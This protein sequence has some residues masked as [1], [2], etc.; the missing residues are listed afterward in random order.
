MGFGFP[1]FELGLML[2][3]FEFCCVGVCCIG[4]LVVWFF[5]FEVVLFY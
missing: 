5:R 3:Q 4:D 2:L 1:D